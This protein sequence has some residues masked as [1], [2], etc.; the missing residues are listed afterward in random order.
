[1]EPVSVLSVVGNSIQLVEFT[2]KLVSKTQ[3]FHR[4]GS[5][6]KQEDLFTVS[7][8]LSSL[9]KTLKTDLDAIV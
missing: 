2:A 6:I 7:N 1:M 3:S 4:S 9:S 8:D 5:L